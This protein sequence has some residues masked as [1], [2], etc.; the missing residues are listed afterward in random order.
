MN[1]RHEIAARLRDLLGRH[2]CSDP[3]RIAPFLGV[4]EVELRISIDELAPYPTLNVL[5]SVSNHYGIDPTYL[6][7]GIYDQDTH[8]CALEG[9]KA[10]ALELL[11][12][13]GA[14]RLRPTPPTG[15]ETAPSRFLN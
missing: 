5:A 11:V 6:V 13:I 14:A 2:G 3:A 8:F 7:T 10:A 1:N 4:D 12:R 15:V 9:G